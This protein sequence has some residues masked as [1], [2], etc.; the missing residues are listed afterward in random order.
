MPNGVENERA[1]PREQEGAPVLLA[2]AEPFDMAALR[3]CCKNPPL[4]WAAL[5]MPAGFE[6]GPNAVRHG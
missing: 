4:S 3:G 1:N 6:R 5:D 2:Q